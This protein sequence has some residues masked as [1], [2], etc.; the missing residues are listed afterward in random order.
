MGL[1]RVSVGHQ[2]GS[3]HLILQGLTRV[4]LEEPVRYK[5]YRVHRI[6]ALAS[7]PCNDVVVDALLAKMRELLEERV[8]LGLPFPF[9]IMSKTKSKPMEPGPGFFLQK[10]CWIIWMKLTDPEQVADLVSLRRAG[11]TGTGGRRIL[12]TVNLELLRLKQLIHFLM[13]EI[14][15][16]K[17]VI[18]NDERIKPASA[19]RA[20]AN[21]S[22][23]G[24][25]GRH[26]IANMVIQ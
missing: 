17:E 19:G 2:D 23:D 24:N 14:S 15:R 13:A 10:R 6:R 8:I 12:E 21:A 3:S 20:E 26:V 16:V 4:E 9:P 1:I 11:G 7:P 5:P 22:R 18:R 25:H